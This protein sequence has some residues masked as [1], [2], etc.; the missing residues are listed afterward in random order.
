MIPF[1]DIVEKLDIS[2][3]RFNGEYM[4]VN[5]ATKSKKSTTIALG[6]MTGVFFVLTAIAILFYCLKRK[7]IQ[8]ETSE[9]KFNQET[10]EDGKFAKLMQ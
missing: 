1:Y 5:S 4:Y 7:S 8:L 6:V 2:P 3:D 10:E 9:E